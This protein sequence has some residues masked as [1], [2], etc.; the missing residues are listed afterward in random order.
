MCVSLSRAFFLAVILALSHAKES[1][2]NRYSNIPLAFSL[3]HTRKRVIFALPHALFLSVV[4]ERDHEKAIFEYTIGILALTH[5]KEGHSCSPSRP[6]F[7]CRSRKRAR[8]RDIRIYHWHSRSP[9]RER[10]S[11]S[12]SL[13]RKRAI[14][15]ASHT[16]FSS[17]VLERVWSW[18]ILK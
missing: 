9:T 3:S 15:A 2:R 12:L 7:E 4:L 17:V 16:L 5:E 8:E 10:G 18:V 1:T 6:L 11:F 13:T 14:L